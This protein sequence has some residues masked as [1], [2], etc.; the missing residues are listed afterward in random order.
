MHFRKNTKYAS[1]NHYTRATIMSREI[2]AYTHLFAK[3]D[4]TRGIITLHRLKALQVLGGNE[5]FF[6]Y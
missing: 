6:F 3:F 4:V 5:I 2:Y 1:I